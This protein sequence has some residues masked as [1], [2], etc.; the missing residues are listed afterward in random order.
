MIRIRF[1]TYY[2]N[3]TKIIK[4]IACSLEVVRSLRIALFLVQFFSKTLSH[5]KKRHQLIDTQLIDG[6]VIPLGL[7]PKT[8]SLEGCCSIQLSYGTILNG[9]AKV[10]IFCQMSRKKLKSAG[11]KGQQKL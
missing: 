2:V 11:R 10:V 1:M 5:K 9:N 4:N 8:H 3:F 7:E 6:V